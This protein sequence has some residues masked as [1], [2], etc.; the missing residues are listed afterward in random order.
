MVEH[1]IHHRGQIYMYLGM[2]G[3]PTPPIFGMTSEEVLEKSRD[4]S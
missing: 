1:E 2:L 4:I 3:I